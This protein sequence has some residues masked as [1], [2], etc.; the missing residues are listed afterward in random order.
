M[1][2]C[3]FLTFL[4]LVPPLESLGT[5]AALGGNDKPERWLLT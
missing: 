4:P 1:T 2:L 3:M 5:D